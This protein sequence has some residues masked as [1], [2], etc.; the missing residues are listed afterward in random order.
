MAEVP[1]DLDRVFAALAD[2]HRRELAA[3]TSNEKG[4]P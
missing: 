3:E 4:R 1:D 2:R